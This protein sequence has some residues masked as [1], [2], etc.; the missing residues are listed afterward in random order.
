M[1][2]FFMIL[3]LF[4]SFCL[5]YFACLILTMAKVSDLE[6]ELWEMKREQNLMLDKHDPPEVFDD[7]PFW[8]MLK[9]KEMNK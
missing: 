8:N 3:S 6:S 2:V 9:A 1:L 4:A 7:D 5:G